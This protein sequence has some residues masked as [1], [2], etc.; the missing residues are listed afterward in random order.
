MQ[1]QERNIVIRTGFFRTS[2]RRI[3]C[4]GPILIGLILGL[5]FPAVGAAALDLRLSG[6]RLSLRADGVPLRQ[7]LGRL[8]GE[9]V[10]VQV[11]PALNPPI[12]ADFSNREMGAALKS[13]LGP[14]DFA[15]IWERA[16]GSSVIRLTEVQVFAPGRQGRVTPLE[17][18]EGFDVVR[19]PEDGSYYLRDEIVL[20]PG[21]DLPPDRLAKIVRELGGQILERDPLIGA[22]RVRLPA[23]TDVPGLIARLR[24]EGVT[25]AAEPH[26]AYP[27]ALPRFAPGDGGKAPSA[28]PIPDGRAPVAVL[29]SGLMAG[30]GLEDQILAS[31]DAVHPDMPITDGLGHG[32]QMALLAGGRVD[33]LGAP[34]DLDD[35]V[36]LVAIRA[37]DDKGF[38][39]NFAV[40][41]AVEFARENGARVLSLSWGSEVRSAFLEAA[42]DAAAR[43]GMVVVASAGNEPTGRP[44]YPAA[45]SSVIGVGAEAPDGSRWDQSN[46]GDFVSVS[47]PGFA[48]LPVGYKGEPGL[49][50]GTSVAAAV[51][52]NRAARHLSD[53]PDADRAAVIRMLEAAF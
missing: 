1:I 12:S 52:A 43:D 27:I 35:Q 46:Y 8:A 20:R 7:V 2:R 17:R 21:P 9:G 48:R 32:T 49:Y 16:A 3:V 13:L 40:S 15:L 6:D 36:P 51:A 28:G 45:Y 11:D 26:Y 24:K 29:D 42:L 23:G 34:V 50:A 4:I 37:F 18:S 33:P 47:A 39:S 41:R 5:L 19:N 10:R 53:H 22:V 31:L 30:A 44:V 38:T 14:L 25:D